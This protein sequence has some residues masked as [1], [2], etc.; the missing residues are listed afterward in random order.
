LTYSDIIYAIEQ[1]NNYSG[2]ISNHKA[3]TLAIL[4]EAQAQANRDITNQVQ[5]DMV[6]WN[7][8]GGNDN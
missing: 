6:H 2:K 4:Y 7:D 8:E 1:Y 3:Y 5:Y